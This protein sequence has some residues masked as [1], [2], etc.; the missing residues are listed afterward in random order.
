MIQTINWAFHVI[1]KEAEMVMEEVENLPEVVE[2][3]AIFGK[4][5]I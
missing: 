3:V 2:S 1:T 5:G 4:S